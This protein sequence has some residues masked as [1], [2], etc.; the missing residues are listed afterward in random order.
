MSDRG[1]CI[2]SRERLFPPSQLDPLCPDHVIEAHA[3]ESDENEK[4][5]DLRRLAALDRLEARSGRHGHRLRL[6]QRGRRIAGI[7]DREDAL[8]AGDFKQL[9]H[10]GIDVAEHQTSAAFHRLMHVD[11]RA[12]PAA[13]HELHP[14]QIEHDAEA[15]LIREVRGHAAQLGRRGDIEPRHLRSRNR[16]IGLVF[17]EHLHERAANRRPGD[18]FFGKKG[19]WAAAPASQTAAMSGEPVPIY[20]EWTQVAF[21]PDVA[22]IPRAVAALRNALVG[23]GASDEIVESVRLG[24]T[25]ALTNAVRHGRPV[26]GQPDVRLRWSW[27][28]EWLVIEVS[29][30]GEFRP[31]ATWT[32]LPADPFAESGRGG[33]LM[34]EHFDEL[35]HLNAHGRHILRLRKRLGLAPHGATSAAELEKTLG[36]M[37]EDLSA[38]YETLSALFKLAEALATS[39]DLAA[40]MNHALRL[41][42]LVDADGMHVR[43]HDPD[44]TLKLLVRSGAAAAAPERL[45]TDGA[46]VEA[47]VFRDG[48]ERTIDARSMLAKDDPLHGL[49]GVAF[50]CPVYF[51]S[52]QLGVCVL[53]RQRQGAYFTAAQISLARTTAEFLGIACANAE[54]QAQRLAQL[55]VQRELEIAAQ[56]QQSLVP[57][58]FPQRRDWEIHGRCVN[59]LEAGG[60]FFDVLEVEGGV[61]LVIADV[62]GKGVPAALLALVLRTAV[63]AHAHLAHHPGKMLDRVATQL[64]PDLER[65]GMF[66][67][68][69][70]VFL[71]S[72][73]PEIVY[74]TAGHGALVVFG[75][76]LA[77]PR[78]LDQG[79]LPLGVSSEE[80]YAE[81]PVQLARGEGLFLFT[82]GLLEAPDAEGRELGLTG[83]LALARDSYSSDLAQLC[84]ALLAR[85][86]AR[87]AGRPATDDRTVL[88]V[89]SLS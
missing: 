32:Q 76:G 78:F 5:H 51:Q 17:D 73:R 36:G 82:D 67:T 37:T 74:A 14:R 23:L 52:R 8:Q 84:A 58:V 31:P 24:I 2:V 38:S 44:R 21:S 34:A 64:A 47:Q 86:Q 39:E 70:V 65:V 79:G 29:E 77:S 28:D 85:V 22:L 60:D 72:A 69:Q 43:L 87:D 80:R 68:A 11:Q 15:I 40:F 45:P 27:P 42:E 57:A 1:F 75:P 30:P 19:L 59:A 4:G 41:R 10:L 33:F 13:I 6:H 20:E 35:T 50:V 26:A 12:E 83:L 55:R 7:R 61:M 46:A 16:M 54:F 56:I 9:R 66:I 18:R 81:H 49:R 71:A 53:V 63:R 25:E 48:L 62:M 89:R 88:V 3:P